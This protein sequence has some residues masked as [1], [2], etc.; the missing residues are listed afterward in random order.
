VQQGKK[1]SNQQGCFGGSLLGC[2]ANNGAPPLVLAGSSQKRGTP[3]PLQTPQVHNLPSHSHPPQLPAS[4][5][6]SLGGGG[7]TTPHL[8]MPCARQHGLL[9]K[10]PLLGQKRRAL[11]PGL[12]IRRHQ[13]QPA[14]KLG[15]PPRAGGGPGGRH[16]RPAGGTPN[17]HK[18]QL[19]RA[20]FGLRGSHKR[21]RCVGG[22][23]RD[24][25]HAD[26]HG[27][28]HCSSAGKASEARLQQGLCTAR[29][30]RHLPLP[31]QRRLH[32]PGAEEQ[33]RVVV[34]VLPTGGPLGSGLPRQPAAGQRRRALHNRQMGVERARS[35]ALPLPSQLCSPGPNAKG[36]ERVGCRRG[37]HAPR[38]RRRPSVTA[39]LPPQQAPPGPRACGRPPQRPPP[40]RCKAP[41]GSRRAA[42]AA[43]QGWA[44]G[45]RERW[46]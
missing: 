14:S 34:A 11:R 23:A 1:A 9:V 12:L 40:Q 24:C 28:A 17:G 30:S 29:Q 22:W 4:D 7:A 43:A 18:V 37:V 46:A 35:E 25:N 42:G 44:P 8:R 5:A 3:W 6:G 10:Q 2:C 15:Q 33:P 27:L 21:R 31:V 13:L 20:A 19:K 39:S 41:A 16:K 36:W 45:W 32:R 38:N 26:W